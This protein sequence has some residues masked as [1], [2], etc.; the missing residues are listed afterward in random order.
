MCFLTRVEELKKM[1]AYAS[2]KI[3]HVKSWKSKMWKPR[4]GTLPPLCRRKCNNM[5]F[6]TARGGRLPCKQ[7]IQVGS[8]PTS[9]IKET[10]KALADDYLFNLGDNKSVVPRE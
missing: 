3:N 7:D 6:G 4:L 2:R 9:S 10:D 8:I 1:S 5:G